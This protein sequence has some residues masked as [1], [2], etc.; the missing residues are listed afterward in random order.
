MTQRVDQLNV[1]GS[2]WELVGLIMEVGAGHAAYTDRF[3]KLARLVPHLVTPESR[4]IKRYV[5]GLALQICEM[6][7]ATE[8][9]IIQKAVQISGA[10][11]DEAVRNG[12]I[13]KV[14]K[15]VNVGEPSKDKNGRD[16]NKRTRTGN[17][18]ATTVNYVGRENMGTWPKCTTCNSYHAPKGPC[19]TCFNCNRPGHLA[20]DCRGVP[21]NVNPVNARNPTVRACYECGSTDHVRSACPILNRAQGPEENRP[22]QVAANNGGQGRGNQGNQA[23]GRAF[24]LGAEEAR[25][26]PNIVTGTFTLNNHFATTLFDSGAD[27]SFVSTTFIPLLG[28]EP[29]E[30]GFRYEI[31]IASGQLVEIDKVIKGCKLEIEGHIFDI[32]LIPFGHRSFDVIIGMDWLSNHKAEIVC[33]EKVV[34]IPLLDGKVLRVLGERP[35]EKARLLISAKASDKSGYHQLRV[36]EDDIL[37]TAF[38]TRYRHFEFTIM[39]FGL[40]NALAVFMY[41]MNGVCRPYLDKFVIVFIDD[42]LIYSKTREE[43]VEHLRLVLELLKREKLHA[44][45]FKCEFW[46]REVQFLGHV[47]NGNGIHVNPSKIEA[48]KNWKALRTPFEVRS[49]LGLAGY[50]HRFIENFSKIAKSLTI[51]TQKCKTFDWGEEQELAFQTLKD[52]LCNAPIL[53]LPDRPEDFVVYYDASGLGLGCVLMQRGKVIAYASRQSKIHE[54]N[55]TTYDLE[56]RAVVFALK[57]WRHYLYGTKSVIYTDH[58]SVQHIFS[59]KELNM[60]QRRWIELFSDYDLR[61]ATILSSIKDRILV[62]QKEA[63]DEFAG[64][65]KGLNKMI[66]QRSDGTLYYLDRIWVPLKG[67]VRTLIMDEA[68]KSKYFVHLVANK[69]YMTLEIGIDGLQPEIPEW[70]WEGIAMDFVTKLPRTSSGHDIIWVIIDRLTKFAHFLPMREDYKMERL[71]RL[72][73]N[74]IVARHGMPIS[75]ISDHDSRFTSRFWQSLQEALGTKLDMSTTYHPFPHLRQDGQSDYN[76]NKVSIAKYEAEVGEGQLIGLEL[77]Q[78]STDKSRKLRIDLKLCLNNKKDYADKRRKPLEVS[79]AEVVAFAC[80]IEIWLLKTCLSKY[81]RDPNI[82]IEEYIRLEEEKAR[83]NVKVYNWE[84]ATYGKIWYDDDVHDLRSVENEFPAIVF[85]DAFTSKVTPS[86]EPTVSPLNDNKID[87][88]ISFDESDDED[89]TLIHDE[90]L[91]SFRNDNDKVNMPSF[92]SPEPEVSYSNNLDF[93][94]DFENEFLAI[95]YNDALTSKSIFFN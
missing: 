78:E 75:I 22:N 79:C 49:F 44:K 24:M 74:E 2:Q 29:S 11:T 48:I 54:K 72:Y 76:G 1:R 45:F 68:H 42:I 64:L 33:H 57:S 15:R 80:V 90:N 77:V 6:V 9:K 10:L 40:T 59:P 12:P 34:R 70:K 25:Q 31:E 20:K 71:A 82:T 38:R 7:A 95:V 5:Y 16:D 27:Y 39:P 47:I 19:R 93:F 35:E 87:F 50:Y 4:M 53:A 41:L 94:K 17:A 43:H 88:R 67:D 28:I 37:K 66:E 83:R 30:L 84:T 65:Q 51:L 92:P 8:P 14:E 73:L 62:A 55:Y 63:V 56:L 81:R 60:Q 58:K 32:N 13:K 52:K 85:D 21:R 86:Y 89:Y 3:N 46:L 23:R 18:F 61:F 36:H 69:M 91:F 26:D